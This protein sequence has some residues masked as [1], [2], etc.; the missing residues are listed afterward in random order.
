MYTGTDL[1]FQEA[2]LFQTVL[3]NLWDDG[4]ESGAGI[5]RLPSSVLE[6]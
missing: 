6:S 5:V 2:S 3:C 4:S 1:I